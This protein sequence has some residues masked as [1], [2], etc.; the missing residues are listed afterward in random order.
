LLITLPLVVA[1]KVINTSLFYTHLVFDQPAFKLLKAMP[2]NKVYIF[3][4]DQIQ[5]SLLTDY[6]QTITPARS[7]ALW[8]IVATEDLINITR[9]SAKIKRANK[10]A[11]FIRQ[12]E[13]NAIIAAKPAIILVQNYEYQV[14]DST[15]AFWSDKYIVTKRPVNTHLQFFLQDNRFAQFWRKHQLVGQADNYSV[16]R[17]D[18]SNPVN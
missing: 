1:C 18:W 6:S 16:Y 5:D 3:T 15:T 2:G 10:I 4:N 14:D 8:L 9:D 7:S 11:D 12:S 17:L 13:I